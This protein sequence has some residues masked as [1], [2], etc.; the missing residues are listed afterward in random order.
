MAES[1][2]M[3]Q[4]VFQGTRTSD[5][6]V[7]E[8]GKVQVTARGLLTDEDL[9]DPSKNCQICIEE[10]RDGGFNFVAGA[11][12][13]WVGGQINPITNLPNRPSISSSYTLPTVPPTHVRVRISSADFISI[14]ASVSFQ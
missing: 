8:P 12:S 11:K 4:D 7:W 9:M 14:G 13:T 3:V 6:K 1:V 5:A 10:S 2:V